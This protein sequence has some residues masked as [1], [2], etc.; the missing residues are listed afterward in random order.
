MLTERN[1]FLLSKMIGLLGSS[2]DGEVMA[3]VRKISDILQS[4]KMSFTDLGMLLVTNGA[5]S[6]NTH[7]EE[8]LAMARALEAHREFMRH[9]EQDFVVSV[10]NR[11]TTGYE[12]TARQANWFFY[13]YAK[14]V[15]ETT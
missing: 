5:Q 8:L 3:A 9:H 14:Y 1:K 10:L 13:L 4:E 12:M 15:E 7:E 2:H 11:L 6:T